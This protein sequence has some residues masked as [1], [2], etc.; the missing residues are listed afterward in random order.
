MEII[1]K[2]HIEKKNSG[3]MLE[4]TNIEEFFAL[5][6][7]PKKSDVNKHTR[8]NENNI[9]TM[10]RCMNLS[11]IEYLMEQFANNFNLFASKDKKGKKCKARQK[12]RD[13]DK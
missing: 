7:S 12:E 9:S 11:A 8:D 13:L 5:P 10:L 6:K 1:Y 4:E 2:E 3:K